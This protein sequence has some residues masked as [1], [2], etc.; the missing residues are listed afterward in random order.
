MNS[1][2]KIPTPNLPVP[3][4]VAANGNGGDSADIRASVPGR[5]WKRAEPIRQHSRAIGGLINPV[6]S[7]V[8]RPETPSLS[9]RSVLDRESLARRFPKPLLGARQTLMT[10]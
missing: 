5:W 2:K 10:H 6:G 8:R 1:V 4:G 3:G 9:A 7:M